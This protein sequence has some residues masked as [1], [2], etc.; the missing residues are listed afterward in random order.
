MDR[1]G[2][3]SRTFA[4]VDVEGNELSALRGLL[5]F[6]ERRLIGLLLEYSSR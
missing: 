5:P 2:G 3:W 4:N 1:G 6:L